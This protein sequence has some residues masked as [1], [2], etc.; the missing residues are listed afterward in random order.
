MLNVV[1]VTFITSSLL[2]KLNQSL[3]IY[4]SDFAIK[5]NLD[6]ILCY[7]LNIIFSILINVT[8]MNNLTEIKMNLNNITIIRDNNVYITDYIIIIVSI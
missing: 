7:K 4:S 2:N 1:H 8:A 5:S 3:A 6:Q